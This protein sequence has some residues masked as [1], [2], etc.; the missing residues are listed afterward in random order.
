[1]PN[2]RS[3]NLPLRGPHHCLSLADASQYPKSQMFSLRAGIEK[4]ISRNAK[5]AAKIPDG[6]SLPRLRGF[7]II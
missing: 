7:L 3:G 5:K 2:H 6:I 4:I 1:V